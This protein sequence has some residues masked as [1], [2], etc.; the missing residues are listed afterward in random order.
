M[1]RE[2]GGIGGGVSRARRGREGEGF[3]VFLGLDGGPGQSA[4]VGGVVLRKESYTAFA[5]TSP[6]SV[7]LLL[8][9]VDAIPSFERELV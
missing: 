5:L 9:D 8:V 2:V 6:P 4:D 1:G 3:A 7:G